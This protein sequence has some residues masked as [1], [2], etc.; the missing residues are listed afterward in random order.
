M[1]NKASLYE[2][3]GDLFSTTQWDLFCTFTYSASVWCQEKVA[4][5]F[6]RMHQLATA[7]HLN[8]SKNNKNFKNSYAKSEKFAPYVLAIEPHKSGT[9]HA[10][11]LIGESF[12]IGS[13][14]E[15]K[16]RTLPAETIKQVWNDNI[17]NAGFT[18][19]EA[20]KKNINAMTYMIKA[21]R[22]CTK[23][24]DAYLDWYGLGRWGV[25]GICCTTGQ[26][27]LLL[28]G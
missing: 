12:P 1:N 13:S 4:R 28:A 14:V 8:I 27:P 20:V 23:N 18:K 16:E 11:A 22:Y 24:P 25:D 6:V 5:D 21:S 2:A 9:L 10:H 26:Y 15:N 17:R 7:S 19:V 3:W